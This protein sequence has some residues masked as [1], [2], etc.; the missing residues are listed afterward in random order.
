MYP[1]VGY[2][3]CTPL[4]GRRGATNYTLGNQSVL[5]KVVGIHKNTIL[6][7]LSIA[8]CSFGVDLDIIGKMA[9]PPDLTLAGQRRFS[10]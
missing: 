5:F 4:W 1:L 9:G 3:L 2:E 8:F 7:D 6:L 10:A